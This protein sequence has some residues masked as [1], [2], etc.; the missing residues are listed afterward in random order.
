MPERFGVRGFDSNAQRL[1]S[2]ATRS[3]SVQ[4]RRIQSDCELQSK[5]GDGVV[6]HP[7]N[8][9]RQLLSSNSTRLNLENGQAALRPQ[10]NHSPLI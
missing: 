7:A 9:S 2:E 8:V 3:K 10:H 4:A 1:I 5:P 6:R